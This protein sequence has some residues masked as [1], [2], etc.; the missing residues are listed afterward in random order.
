[1]I[2]DVKLFYARKTIS[3]AYGYLAKPNTEKYAYANFSR[4]IVRDWND[5]LLSKHKETINFTVHD[6]QGT[7]WH[8]GQSLQLLHCIH[9]ILNTITPLH[10]YHK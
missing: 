2:L 7:L 1:M 3:V 5:G 8:K 9:R 10:I 6:I 4:N